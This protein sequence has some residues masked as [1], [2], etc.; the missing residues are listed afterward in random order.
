M[1]IKYQRI[2]FVKDVELIKKNNTKCYMNDLVP[3]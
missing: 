1:R 2:T 3:R